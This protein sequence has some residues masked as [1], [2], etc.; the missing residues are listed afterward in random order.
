MAYVNTAC[1]G[2]V[3]IFSTGGKFRPVSNFTWLHALTLAARS[4]AL[5]I[6]IRGYLCK[7]TGNIC[8]IYSSRMRKRQMRKRSLWLS[9]TC[10]QSLQY[11]SEV[12]MNASWATIRWL[13]QQ[14]DFTMCSVWFCKQSQFPKTTYSVLTKAHSIQPSTNSCHAFTL[15][16]TKNCLQCHKSS[17]Y[18]VRG[19]GSPT[20]L[21]GLFC[22]V[23]PRFV[24][25]NTL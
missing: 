25:M 19:I 18:K 20:T 17:P 3:T 22:S 21:S 13:K 8:V 15:C 4:Y 7:M 12:L 2:R 10:S 9:Y 14:S 23:C 24:G 11:Q 6:G 1:A 5:L 16:L